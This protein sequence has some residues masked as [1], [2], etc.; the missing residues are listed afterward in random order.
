VAAALKP[1][2]AI[3]HPSKLGSILAFSSDTANTARLRIARGEQSLMVLG[4]S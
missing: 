4:F 1:P 2:L 3:P